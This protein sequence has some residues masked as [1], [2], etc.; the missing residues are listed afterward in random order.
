MCR[1]I[2]YRGE[3]TPLRAVRDRAGPF[4]GGAEPAGARVDRLDQRRRFWDGLVRRALGTGPLSRGPPGLVGRKPALPLPPHPIAPVF[5]PCARLDR[6][7]DHAAELPSVRLRALDVHAQRADRQLV[8]AAPAGRVADPR[9]VVRLAHRHDQFGGGV[10]GHPGRRRR[11]GPG[12]R[13][14]AHARHADRHAAERPNRCASRPRSPTAATST[15]SATPPTTTP[16]RSITANRATTSWWCPS[17]SIPSGRT[18]SRCRPATCWW[19]RP[20]NRSR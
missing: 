20:A 11:P 19:R 4:A 12:R 2:A 17:R 16:I 3:A 13:H 8:A 14:H 5:R 15:P 10:P 7:P 18:G 6:H 9:R 1:W